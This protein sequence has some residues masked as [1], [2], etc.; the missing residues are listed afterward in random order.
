MH[1]VTASAME[2]AGRVARLCL[3]AIVGFFAVALSS[4]D[5]EADTLSAG[6]GHTCAVTRLGGVKCWGD[7]SY[8]GLGD[9]TRNATSSPV[10][11]R[12]L[13]ERVTDVSAGSFYSC[14]LT[15]SGAV[16][17]WGY[18]LNGQLGIGIETTADSPVSVSALDAKVRA[19]ATGPRHACAL[20]E[21]G[22]VL[23]WGNNEFGQLGDGSEANSALPVRVSGLGPGVL[24]VAAGDF[25]SCAL[26]AARGVKCWGRNDSGQLGDGTLESRSSPVNV[27]GLEARVT[28]L[29]LATWHSC[30]LTVAGQVKCWGSNGAGGF[31]NGTYSSSP[32]P[33]A[34]TSLTEPAVA[35][36][37]ADWHTCAL[38]SRGAVK[39]WG[40]NPDGELGDGTTSS[41]SR[42]ID[43]EGLGTGVVALAAGRAHT[44]AR[45]RT[46][47]VRC[48]GRGDMDQLGNGIPT[49]REVP[50]DVVGLGAGAIEVATAEH[51]ACAVSADG[52]ASCW[53]Q[54]FSG[55]LG[56]GTASSRSIASA[57][58]G[59]GSPLIAIAT[60]TTHS[61]AITQRN[62]VWC[63]GFG[64]YGQLGDGY[65][66]NRAEPVATMRLDGNAA[67][68]A[69]GSVHSCALTLEGE[70]RCWGSNEVG[71]LGVGNNISGRP[72]PLLV[73]DL[74]PGV[75]AIAAGAFHSC[76]LT[77]AGGVKCWGQNG[78]HELGDGTTTNRNG[79]VDVQ[80]LE[81]DVVAISAH[82][83]QTCALTQSDAVKCW[84]NNEGVPVDVAGLD[85]GIAMIAVGAAHGCA[86]M[87][88]GSLKCWGANDDGQ[89][90]DGTRD[91]RP[92]AV[93]VM[94]SSRDVSWVAAGD[95]NTCVI[96]GGVAKCW[97]NNASGQVG[98]GEAGYALVPAKVVGSPFASHPP[99]LRSNPLRFGPRR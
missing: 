28:A 88:T 45:L 65:K 47:E 23:C 63:W 69:L 25:Y 42:A 98:N 76:A 67:E 52:T 50:T 86:L 61:C 66:E 17:C 22:D 40:Y 83:R 99:R 44:C 87:G 33:V 11:V 8:F 18:G 1:H 41:S 7:N 89:L 59:M 57:V 64:V 35:I 10:D 15:A 46:G 81:A 80:G 49:V 27:V 72:A 93:E 32:V 24:A 53:G 30:A 2:L 90:G 9:G 54:N 12:G 91:Y 92:Y 97:G 48:W 39:C 56:D 78:A 60:G 94:E 3:A 79:P 62:A 29:S 75:K 13:Q 70:V 51:H 68:L 74:G 19:I 5:V 34:A 82:G 58:T 26:T 77:A 95:S 43:V 36:A 55:E 21:A 71:Q 16:K 20:T 6:F 38:T 4:R 96:A 85:G 73:V 31:G 14:A 37:A 84:G